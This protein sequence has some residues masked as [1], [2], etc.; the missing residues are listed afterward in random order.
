MLE[1]MQVSRKIMDYLDAFNGSKPVVHNNDAM[2]IKGI[3]R[4]KIPV[5]ERQSVL[6]ETF[7]AMNIDEIPVDSQ[8]A[9]ELTE[10]IDIVFKKTTGVFDEAN[11]ILGIEKLKNTFEMTGF[12][13]NYIM[14]KKD[15]IAV[16]IAMW[17]DKSGAGP[18]FVECMVVNL[19]AADSDY[20][21]RKDVSL[22]DENNN[23]GFDLPFDM[24]DPSFK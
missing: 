17:S 24:N 4:R 14:G 5:D 9:S 23:G 21:I 19:I 20:D 3:S 13:I 22:S 12:A 16:Y 1:V 2:I 7:L 11:G 8:E 10:K 15:N 6:N 18:M